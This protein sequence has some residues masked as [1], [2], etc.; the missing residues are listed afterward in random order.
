MFRHLAFAAFAAAVLSAAASS[1]S[2]RPGGCD[3]W[4]CGMNGTQL[5][6]IAEHFADPHPNLVSAVILPRLSVDQEPHTVVA[7]LNEGAV[8][9]DDR[10]RKKSRMRDVQ[11]QFE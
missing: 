9:Q 8:K 6:G 5:T 10:L 3:D 1:S 4:G 7:G 11:R 2:A